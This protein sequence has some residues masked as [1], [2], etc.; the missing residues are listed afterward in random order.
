MNLWPLIESVMYRGLMR[1][2]FSRV[3]IVDEGGLAALAMKEPFLIAANHQSHADTPV[4]FG[5]LPRACRAR[6]RVVSGSA[7]FAQSGVVESLPARIERWFLHGLACH[8]Y[9]AILVTGGT[10]GPRSIERIAEALAAGD[11]IAIYPEGTRS[12]DGRLGPLKPGVAV[13]ATTTGCPVIPVRLDGIFEALPKSA[14][15]VRFRSHGIVRFRRPLRAEPGESTES[16]LARLTDSLA[17]ADTASR[18]RGA[19]HPQAEGTRA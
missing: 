12:R 11:C 5:S 4:L 15:M 7:R 10:A 14:W 9:R 2:T 18:R 8:A 13:L 17:P 19:D 6:M 3:D 1:V 16:F